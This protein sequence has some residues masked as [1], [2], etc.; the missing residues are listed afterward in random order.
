MST[1]ETAGHNCHAMHA[2]D[3]T[4]KLMHAIHNLR[5]EVYCRERGF[6]PQE[7]Y[8]ERCEQDIYDGYSIH[9]AALHDQ[10]KVAGTLRLILPSPAGFPMFQHCRLH[11]DCTI[12]PRH[13]SFAPWSNYAEISRLAVSR[14]FR[15]VQQ[16]TIYGA[17]LN[18]TGK[19][20]ATT[21]C[22]GEQPQTRNSPRT[23]IIYKLYRCLYQQSKR[24]GITHWLAAMEPTLHTLLKRIG[25]H[26]T[27]VGPEVDYHGPVTPYVA[28]ITDLE[29]RLKN[30]NPAL[31][32]QM[33]QGLESRYKPH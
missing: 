7:D 10:D 29:R 3:Q 33:T 8:Q 21:Y 12:L 1:Q 18:K 19:Q 32:E 14:Q 22:L 6:L 30:Y 20:I 23:A 24:Q 27:A 25:L 5:Y 13:G 2:E 15:E 28:S 26:F 11:D 9:F 31:L 16:D 4:Q 17:I